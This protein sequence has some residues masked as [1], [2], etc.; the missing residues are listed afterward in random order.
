M[1]SITYI[2]AS[3]R[4]HLV[5]VPAGHSLMEGAR[6]NDVPGILA[7]CSGSCACGTCKVMVA[8]EWRDRLPRM[9]DLESATIEMFDD[10]SPG[11][12]LAC[13]IVVS[14]DMAGM[15]VTMPEKQF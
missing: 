9:N 15:V 8:A 3:G 10:P 4:Q 6:D 7:D 12:R 11:Q 14:E 13:Q 5:D 2:E 1:P